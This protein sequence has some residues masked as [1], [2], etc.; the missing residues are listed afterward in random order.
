MI[1]RNKFKAIG[2]LSRK[3]IIMLLLTSLK[4]KA[5]LKLKG[6]VLSYFFPPIFSDPFCNFLAFF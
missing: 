4:A 2:I 3:T 6:D 1:D 5:K